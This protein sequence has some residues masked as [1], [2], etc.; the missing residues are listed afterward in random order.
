MRSTHPELD[1]LGIHGRQR[2]NIAHQWKR[3]RFYA[4]GLTSRGT[5]RKLKK[6]PELKGLSRDEQRRRRNA[7]YNR[8]IIEANIAAGLTA[9]GK[10]R[11]IGRLPDRELAW[12]RFRAG[13]Q[14]THHTINPFHERSTN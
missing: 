2:Y 14:V 9:W 4:E 8:K 3:N 11:K 7:V 5:P 12:R 6:W 1:R 13:L 10:P